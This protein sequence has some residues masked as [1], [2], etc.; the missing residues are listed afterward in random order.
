[1][2]RPLR[3]AALTLALLSALPCTLPAA[4]AQSGDDIV[5]EARDALRK[6]D[7]VKL[8][9][10]RSLVNAERHPLASWVEYWELSNRLQQAT[11]EEVEAFYARWSGTYVED[12]LRN[13]WL[14][15]LG[16]RRDWSA[17][18]R[19]YPR[20][21]MNDDR[22]VSCY[23][24]LTEHLA[25]KDVR[26]AA[27][28]AWLGQRDADDGCHLL[29]TTLVRAGVFGADEVWQKL[30]LAAEGNRP[31][32]ARAVAALLNA[33]AAAAAVGDVFDSPTRY[34]VR[35]ASATD[36]TGAE[37]TALA[38]ARAAAADPEAA[39][40]LASDWQGRL[41]PQLAGWVWGQIG[42]QGALKLLPQASEWYLRAG[43]LAAAPGPKVAWSEDMLAWQ[44]RAALRGSPQRWTLV[45][46][47]VDAM[48][49]AR[50]REPVWVYW[51]ARAL[52]AEAAPGPEG[53]SVRQQA[54]RALADIASGLSYYGKLATEELGRKPAL[55]PA[56]RPPTAAE[57]AAAID[58]PGLTRALQLI[59][60]GLR[61]EGV[62]EWNFT[63]RGMDDR[64]LLAAAQRAC[65]REVWDRCI[66]TSERTRDE[67]DMAQR[68]P[69]PHRQAVLRE[70]H[71]I[72]IDPAYVYGLIR[73]ESRF[74]TNARSHVGASG[75]MQVMPDTARWTA[76]KLGI[77]Y[78]PDLITDRDTNLRIGTGYLKLVLDS[79]EGHQALAA[80]AY[81]AGPGR[82]RRWRQGATLEAAVWAENIP[83]TETRDYVQKVL[84][85]AT[86]YAA[87]IS[88]QAP[89]IKARLGDTIGP[90]A[91]RTA[92]AELP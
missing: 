15:E 42:L 44:A 37:L 72:G 6:R 43:A 85:N 10:A 63:L 2:N 21:R 87:L 61:N 23:A 24:L 67:V 46:D 14:L 5:V 28:E 84:S 38:L 83:F 56:P 60:L 1:M 57:R 49:P 79:F 36:R 4:H 19:D 68:F 64:A 32:A 76:K 16:K 11:T 8:A 70:A 54:Q 12:R 39:A 69:M 17:F 9:A 27:R 59:D 80:A 48:P 55:P 71:A 91:P 33:P 58:N 75:L 90:S 7:R 47:A 52:L 30:R 51:K 88:G 86:D 41:P 20:F 66:N 25:G 65:E 3:L 26:E 13:D 73:Q 53:D 77:D 92:D 89:S 45:R 35:K 34:L 81:N 74:I 82:P 31:K 78:T 62:R 50:Q 29:A 22:E 40:T 18:S